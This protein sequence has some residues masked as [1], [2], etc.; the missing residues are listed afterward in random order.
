MST[1]IKQ[2]DI[3]KYEEKEENLFTDDQA[4]DEMWGKKLEDEHVFFAWLRSRFEDM[5]NDFSSITGLSS[6]YYSKLV[7][8]LQ[9]AA[10]VGFFFGEL[11]WNK[12]IEQ[13]LNGVFD[14]TDESPPEK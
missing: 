4:Y 9:D 5:A 3:K 2:E 10:M 8:I 6:L 14:T 1:L 12:D 11:R 13:M 7:E